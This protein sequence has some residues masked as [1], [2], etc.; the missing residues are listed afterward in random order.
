MR[1]KENILGQSRK[2]P[3]ISDVDP[4]TPARTDELLHYLVQPSI[5]PLGV[6]PI[7]TTHDGRTSMSHDYPN[8]ARELLESLGG[9]DNI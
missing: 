5:V 2:N 8:I 9:R 4:R 7:T 1:T 3:L 6:R